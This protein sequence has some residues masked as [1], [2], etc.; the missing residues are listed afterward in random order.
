MHMK[1]TVLVVFVL[2][3]GVGAPGP[4]RADSPLAEAARKEKKRRAQT[5]APEKV[6]TNDDLGPASN[7]GA[8]VEET[9]ADE[10]GK[11]AEGQAAAAGDAK[12]ADNSA[13]Q[14]EIQREINAQVER[15]KA[16]RKQVDDAERELADQLAPSYG[17]RR[18]QVAQIRD[19]GQKAIA[20]IEARIAELEA[21]AKRLGVTVTRPQ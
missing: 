6:H 20:D 16:V 14:A 8:P 15:I 19:D 21:E 3:L 2:A 5:K 17:P 12:P 11:P 7:V 1:T 13:R 10:P 4:V 9:T 18:A